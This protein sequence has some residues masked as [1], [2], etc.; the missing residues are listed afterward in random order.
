MAM[1]Y[2]ITGVWN[3]DARMN[4]V[5]TAAAV[6]A[7]AVTAAAATAAG[8]VAAM[9]VAVAAATLQ[10]TL[11][12]HTSSYSNSMTSTDSGCSS[13]MLYMSCTSS[14]GSSGNT[15]LSCEQE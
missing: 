9:T 15:S 14:S 11:H 6:P 7:A 12:P 4:T 2:D 10:V 8:A 3:H 1:Y 13:T 5:A